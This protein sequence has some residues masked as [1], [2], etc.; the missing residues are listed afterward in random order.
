[1][2]PMMIDISK[3]S[4]N[5]CLRNHTIGRLCVISLLLNILIPTISPSQLRIQILRPF[6]G[7]ESLLRYGLTLR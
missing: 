1:M 6:R 7:V 3:K 2:M 5:K 4:S